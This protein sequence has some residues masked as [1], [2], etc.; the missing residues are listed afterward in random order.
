MLSRNANDKRTVSPE[1]YPDTQAIPVIY[2]VISLPGVDIETQVSLANAIVLLSKHEQIQMN[3]IKHDQ[4]LIIL[5]L[6]LFS[7]TQDA[8]SMED[9]HRSTSHLILQHPVQDAEDEAR[10]TALRSALSASLWDTTGLAEFSVKYLPASGLVQRLISWLSIDEPQM[11]VCACSILRNVASSDQN[12]TDLVMRFKIQTVLIPVLDG[13]SNLQVLEESLRLMKNLAVPAANKEELNV[14]DSVTL[15]WSKFESPTLHYAAASLVRQLLRGCFGNVNRFLRAVNVDET[16]SCTS[17]LLR[18][19]SNTD[20]SAIKIEVAR[21]VVDM[22]R[23][24]NSGKS[25]EVHSQVGGMEKALREGELHPDEMVKPIIAMITKSENPSLVTEGWFGLALMARSKEFSEAI[26]NALHGSVFQNVFRAA[27][28]SP[29]MHSKDRDN[30]R[31]LADRLLKH[32]VS[33]CCN[34]ID[35]PVKV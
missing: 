34:I 23:T 6:F 20:D 27:V 15:L 14:L 33:L 7:Y 11:Q 26:H 30:S 9:R 16:D 4:L 13:S 29:D 21:T 24:A 22:W 17:R 35:S 1:L 31:I 25:E 3:L 5:D 28:Y 12:A 32:S 19:Y 2:Q 18:L 8:T 10:L